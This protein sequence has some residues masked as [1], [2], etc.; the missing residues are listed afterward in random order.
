MCQ[1]ES[2]KSLAIQYYLPGNRIAFLRIS[3]ISLDFFGDSILLS[4]FCFLGYI[5]TNDT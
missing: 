1:L 4:W 5:H 3:R 2:L